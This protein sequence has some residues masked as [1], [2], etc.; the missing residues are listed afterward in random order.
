MENKKKGLTLVE[1]IVTV[2]VLLILIGAVTVGWGFIDR[3]NKDFDNQ[4]AQNY[5]NALKI[6]VTNS[7]KNK[8][9]VNLDNAQLV[10]NAI[11][12]VVGQSPLEL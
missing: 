5:Q 2:C 11:A 10:A 7:I 12:G 9:T 4:M 3:S 6:Y 8:N 1:L